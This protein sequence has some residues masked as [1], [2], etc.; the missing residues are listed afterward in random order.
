VGRREN[1]FL[2]KRKLAEIMGVSEALVGFWEK[3]ERGIPVEKWQQLKEILQL[4]DYWDKW[5]MNY[6]ERKVPRLP[7]PETAQFVRGHMITLPYKHRRCFKG[8]TDCGCNAGWE[9]GIV[10]D[11]FMGSGTTAIVAQGLGRNWIGIELNPEY[12]EMAYRIY[13][14]GIPQ[15]G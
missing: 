8:W 13:R 9:A 2:S 12:I 10:L 4:D 5:M 6:S 14:N 11:P 1:E 7:R 15:V 3:G